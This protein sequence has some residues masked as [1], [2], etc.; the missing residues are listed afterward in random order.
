MEDLRPLARLSTPLFNGNVPVKCNV[1]FGINECKYEQRVWLDKFSVLLSCCAGDTPE[2]ELKIKNCANSPCDQKAGKISL[3]Q[4]F[5]N[6]V[7][8]RW[9]KPYA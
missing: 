3:C 5:S 6:L 4:N 1:P 9:C 8:V 7:Y 2:K